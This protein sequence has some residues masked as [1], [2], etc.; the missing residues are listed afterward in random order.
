MK[1]YI[2]YQEFVFT[3]K[4]SFFANLKESLQPYF[5]DLIL[6]VTHNSNVRQQFFSSF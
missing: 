4:I 5:D 2:T 6:A 1:N 3:L